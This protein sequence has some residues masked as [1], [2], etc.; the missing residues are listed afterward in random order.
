[1]VCGAILMRRTLIIQTC[2]RWMILQQDRPDD[3]VVA[4]GETHTVREFVEK[5][6]KCVGITI[7]WRG[8][9]SSVD[10]VGYEAGTERALVKIDPKYFRP[11]EV[12]AEV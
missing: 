4:T 12:G 2:N 3:F 1:M 7:E 5:S 8:E 10:E 11:T 6:F 9:H